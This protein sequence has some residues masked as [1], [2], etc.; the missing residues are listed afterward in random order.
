MHVRKEDSLFWF[1]ITRASQ[2]VAFKPRRLR[3]NDAIY[4]DPKVPGKVS[5]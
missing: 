3:D 4:L 2:P 5:T 1:G